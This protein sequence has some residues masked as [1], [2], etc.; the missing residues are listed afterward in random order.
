MGPWKEKGDAG[1]EELKYLS[2]FQVLLL[3]HVTFSWLG[4]LPMFSVHFSNSF[5]A[6]TY[7]TV[8]LSYSSPHRIHPENTVRCGE[9][10]PPSRREIGSTGLWPPPP[11]GA[12][13]SISGSPSVGTISN[14]P[15]PSSTDFAIAFQSFDHCASFAL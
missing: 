6:S 1:Y 15:P 8:Y 4:F 9:R 13:L 11:P 7:H 10:R 3:F 14:P 5:T 2:L 12:T